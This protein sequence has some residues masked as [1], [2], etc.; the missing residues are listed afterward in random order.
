MGCTHIVEKKPSRSSACSTGHHQLASGKTQK[1]WNI[2]F[3]K[4]KVV[5]RATRPTDAL[6][7]L[8]WANMATGRLLSRTSTTSGLCRQS[9]S[10]SITRM[11]FCSAI[12]FPTHGF[13]SMVARHRF[14]TG[15]ESDLRDVTRWRRSRR[16]Q[17]PQP[18]GSGETD[19]PP[20]QQGIVR[21][22]VSR[23]SCRGGL[24]RLG[25]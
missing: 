13:E 5:S 21:L 14:G 4:A 6:V 1:E 12:C 8:C 24:S 20:S 15:V 22:D 16:Q 23:V 25:G 7:I 9:Q 2:P 10:G 17:T 11:G 3:F 18:R 19:L